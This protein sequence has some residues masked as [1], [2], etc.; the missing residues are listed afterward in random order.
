VPFDDKVVG[1]FVRFRA[2]LHSR[3]YASS[4]RPPRSFTSPL[5]CDSLSWMLA[6]GQ[7]P[8]SSTSALARV[9]SHHDFPFR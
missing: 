9:W 3:L 4:S 1:V 5:V 8:V 2:P 7:L 6:R